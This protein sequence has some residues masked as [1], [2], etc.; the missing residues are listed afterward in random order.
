MFF[1]RFFFISFHLQ[2]PIFFKNF[3][4]QQIAKLIMKILNVFV[5]LISDVPERL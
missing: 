4:P 2:L 3:Y 1:F 5:R